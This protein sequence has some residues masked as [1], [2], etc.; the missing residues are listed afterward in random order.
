MLLILASAGCLAVS[1]YYTIWGTLLRRASL[2]PGPQGLP[3]VGNLFDLP[4]DYDWLH[5][6][7][8]KAKYGT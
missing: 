4:N 3:F 7:T 2:P 8:F 1:L 5:W 6:A